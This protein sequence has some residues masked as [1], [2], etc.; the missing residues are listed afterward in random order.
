MTATGTGAKVKAPSEGWAEPAKRSATMALLPLLG[1]LLVVA[2]LAFLWKAFQGGEIK[3]GVVALLL[4][5]LATLLVVELLP[6][7][8]SLKLGKDGV[9]LEFRTLGEKVTGDN[10][11]L[12]DR[13]AELERAVA[14]CTPVPVA[15][16]P[17]TGGAKRVTKAAPKARPALSWDTPDRLKEAGPYRND[18]RKGVFGGRASVDGF[19]LSAGF[20]GPP[21]QAWCE[22][23]LTV[24]AD[25]GANMAGVTGVE[26]FLHD[27][28]PR[29]RVRVPFRDGKA[30]LERT[31]WGGFTVGVWIPGPDVTLELDLALLPYAPKV[32]KEL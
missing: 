8:Q 5:G 23:I 17:Q 15:T 6:T 25:A 4:V 13:I 22:V 2:S 31:T 26:F 19:T 14:A 29:A 10:D 1:V 32:V 18:L 12:R 7:L 16:T 27:S 20:D 30:Q 24:T 28:F 11:A 9:E 3:D 21:S